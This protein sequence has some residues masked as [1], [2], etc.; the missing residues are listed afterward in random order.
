MNTRSYILF[1]GHLFVL[2][3]N[4]HNSV[5][6]SLS[7]NYNFSSP[8]VLAGADLTYIGDASSLGDRISLTKSS[9]WSSGIVASNR[10]LRLWDNTTT[11]QLQ[12]ASF[13]T[14]FSIAINPV[15]STNQGDGMAFFIRPYP[16]SMPLDSLGGFLALFTNPYNPNNTDFA[17]AVGVEFDP[18]ENEMWDPKNAGPH[19]GIDVNSITSTAYTPMPAPGIRGTIS[20]S[21][22]YDAASSTLDVAVRFHDLPG[23]TSRSLTAKVDMGKSALPQ[24]VAVGFS[25]ATGD[26]IEGH[27]VL[28]WSFDSSLSSK[29][30]I[31]TGKIFLAYQLFTITI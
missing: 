21:V 24:E 30:S 20:A 31:A 7:F 8:G 14:N 17:P 11:N 29:G 18:Y 9:N 16:A 5:V 22:S 3:I 27:Q 2:C 10:P 6:V 15:N 26:Y 28:S 19:V 12:I 4:N 23:V 13:T 25:G 1:L